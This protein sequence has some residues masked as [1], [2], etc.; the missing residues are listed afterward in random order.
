MLY[1]EDFLYIFST[2]P[3]I[4]LTT[5][6]QFTVFPEISIFLKAVRLILVLFS[7]FLNISCISL[8]GFMHSHGFNYPLYVYNAQN[9]SPDFYWISTVNIQQP[10]RVIYKGAVWTSKE[11]AMSVYS[12]HRPLLPLSNYPPTTIHF[13]W[14]RSSTSGAF[15]QPVTPNC[16]RRKTK[17]VF[18]F[19]SFSF[20]SVG[21]VTKPIVCNLYIYIVCKIYLKSIIHSLIQPIFL[22]FMYQAL[23]YTPKYTTMNKTNSI[24][25]FMDSV[26]LWWKKKKMLK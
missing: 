16:T 24:L 26:L 5:L 8:G 3:V 11:Y 2:S 22:S 21:I 17:I 18:Y 12:L 20:T 6:S 14:C 13:S 7:P 25:A 4:F 15:L 9:L 19:L 1:S 23:D 10:T